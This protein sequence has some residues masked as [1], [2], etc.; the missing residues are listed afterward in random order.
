M[1]TINSDLTGGLYH[2]PITVASGQPIIAR[3]EYIRLPKQGQACPWTG[4]GRSKLW[5]ILQTGRVR[6]VCLR[7]PG[8]LKG[9]RLVNL[10]SLLCYLRAL[11]TETAP[12]TS[13]NGTE[14]VQ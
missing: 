2:G 7:K 11:E 4:L 1:P 13:T 10:E 3:P 5:E 8:A 6:S 9:A 12:T 14:V